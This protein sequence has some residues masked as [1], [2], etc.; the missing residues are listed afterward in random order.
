MS[1]QGHC[2]WTQSSTDVLTHLYLW[3]SCPGLS[4]PWTPPPRTQICAQ[5]LTAP[6]H[7]PPSSNLLPSPLQ[8]RLFL[9]LEKNSIP[10]ALPHLHPFP[11][12]TSTDFSILV[13][14]CSVTQSCPILCNPVDCSRTGSSVHW[15]LQARTLE[16]VAIPFS[17]GSSRPRDLPDPGIEPTTL[18]SPAL[19]GRDLINIS[20]WDAHFGGWNAPNFSLS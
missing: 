20:A 11:P 3:S 5:N 15:I 16:L 10:T 8:D 17:R 7:R 14:V 18:A 6:G 2:W 1:R 19:A 9:P 4:V 13:G 12:K